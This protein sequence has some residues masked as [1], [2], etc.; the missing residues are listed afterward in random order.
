[1]DLHKFAPCEKSKNR[2]VNLR[3]RWLANATFAFSLNSS[4][5][6]IFNT[7]GQISSL[8]SLRLGKVAQIMFTFPIIR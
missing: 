7:F 4:V 8:N 2:R 3:Q 5:L 6:K 1:M